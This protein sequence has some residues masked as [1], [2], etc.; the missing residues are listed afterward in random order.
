M[1]AYEKGLGCVTVI[2]RRN[3]NCT[4]L[5]EHK[6]GANYLGGRTSRGFEDSHLIR[7]LKTFIGPELNTARAHASYWGEKQK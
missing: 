6:E 1:L 5:T 2:I 7:V 3:V 4:V